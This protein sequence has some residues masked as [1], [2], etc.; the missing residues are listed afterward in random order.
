MA[1]PMASL[2]ESGLVLE[3]FVSLP[4]RR[5][6]DSL[7]TSNIK[8]FCKEVVDSVSGSGNHQLFVTNLESLLTLHVLKCPIWIFKWK[9]QPQ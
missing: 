6:F 7:R 4:S 9:V 1:M 8:Q 5:E 3:A 2:F